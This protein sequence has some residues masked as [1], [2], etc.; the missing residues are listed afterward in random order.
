MRLE[1][2]LKEELSRYGPDQGA[3]KL[4]HSKVFLSGVLSAV[5]ELTHMLDDA[6]VP[7]T[8]EVNESLASLTVKAGNL[9]DAT[10]P[11]AED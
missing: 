6:G 7:E 1:L 10:T 2:Q 8:D 3:L 5:A 11:T 4:Y 9:L